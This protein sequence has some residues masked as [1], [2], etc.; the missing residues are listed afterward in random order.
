[1]PVLTT[2][3][4]M[5]IIPHRQPML[6]IDTIEELE[7]GKRGVGKKCVSFN[8][9]YFAG[10]FPNEPVMPG[11]LTVEALAQVGAVVILSCPEFKGKTAYFGAINSCK[12]KRKIVPGDVVYL[13]VIRQKGPIGIGKATATVDG[14]VAVSAE[15]T[16][17]I[18]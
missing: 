16:F 8:E 6:L 1:M 10:H 9:P 14:E 12:F 2:K 18:G 11:V 5:E 13:E 7:P 15:L 4:I 17:A 3:Q